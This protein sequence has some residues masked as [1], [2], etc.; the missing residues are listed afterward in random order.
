MLRM[1][2]KKKKGGFAAS[3]SISPSAVQVS[4]ALLSPDAFGGAPGSSTNYDDLL[5]HNGSDDADSDDGDESFQSQ[6][7]SD[8][9]SLVGEAT[10][11]DDGSD[12]D[13]ES[14]SSLSGDDR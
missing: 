10:A 5:H 7:T 4:P 13:E 14:F 1:L 11:A 2:Q 6:P 9:D 3:S 8:V 12:S